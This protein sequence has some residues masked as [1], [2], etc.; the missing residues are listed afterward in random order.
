MNLKE[1]IA[2]V[3]DARMRY[4]EALMRRVNIEGEK[5]RYTNIL[6]THASDLIKAA[7]KAAE[8]AEA[9]EKAIHAFERTADDGPA[10]PSILT[11]GELAELAT[12]MTK[13]EQYTPG[14]QLAV[15]KSEVS[16]TEPESPRKGA[17]KDGVSQ[18]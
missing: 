6:I 1:I 10:N 12:H 18:A 11:L 3:D 13:V 16:M 14:I 15:E 4:E 5:R 17:K 2:L 9:E 8:W 7:Q